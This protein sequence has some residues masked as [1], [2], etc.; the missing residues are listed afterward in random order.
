MYFF[1]VLEF[2]R[3]FFFLN[4]RFK[5]SGGLPLVHVR[6]SDQKI[7]GVFDLINS[8]PLPQKSSVSVPSTKVN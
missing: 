4:K 5:V 7:R 8:I 6:F 1:L 2:N 3:F